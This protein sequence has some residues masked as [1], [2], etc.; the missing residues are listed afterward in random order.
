MGVLLRTAVN[1]VSYNLPLCR[2]RC[3][4][5]ITY[6]L[7]VYSILTVGIHTMGLQHLDCWNIHYVSTAS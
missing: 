6:T 3:P 5:G 1:F 4:Y 7:W 2:S